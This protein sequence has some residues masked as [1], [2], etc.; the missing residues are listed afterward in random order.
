MNRKVFLNLLAS[1]WLASRAFPLLAASE[2]SKSNTAKEIVFYVSPRGNDQWTGLKPDKDGSNGPFATITRARDE[3]R[4]LKQKSGDT[5]DRPVRVILRGGTYFVNQTIKFTE[6]D[7]GSKTTPIIYQAYKNE[8]PIL[9]GGKVIN[10]WKQLKVNGKLAWTSTLPEVQQGKW[11][12]HQLWVNGDRAQRCRHPK[13]GYL[14]VE[15][16]FNTTT[17]V[18]SGQ[19]HFQYAQGDLKAWKDL[20]Q[21]EAIIMSRW[22]ESRLP[23]TSI[24]TEQQII[25]FQE[26]TPLQ[27]EA[28]NSSSS[29]A[30]TYYLENILEL[31]T[32]PGEWHL[33]H[34]TGQITYLPRQGESIY[35]SI[36]I[37]PVLSKLLEITGDISTRRSV[38]YITFEGIVF[39]HGEWYY[40]SKQNLNP[41]S[42]RV[43]LS[44]IQ[45]SANIPGYIYVQATRFCGWRKC[46]FSH[47]SNYAIE[48][49]DS[50]IENKITDCKFSDLGAGG[51]KIGGMRNPSCG[52]NIVSNCHIYNGGIIFHSA[53]GIWIGKSSNNI[54]TNNHIHDFYY[55]AI[56][57]GW[58]WGY[59]EK[60]NSKKPEAQNNIIQNNHIHD[61]GKKSNNDRPMLNDKGGIYTLGIQPGTIISGNLIHNVE[62]YNYGAAGIYLDEGSSNIL[63]DNNIVH[64]IRGYCFHLHYGRNNIIR[65]N[66]F[67]LAKIAQILYS[68]SEKEN[69]ALI[70]Q[71]N[72]IYW[73]EGKLLDGKW[74]DLNFIFDRNIYWQQGNHQ[75]KFDQLSWQNWRKQ[76]MDL[77]SE[78]IDPLFVNPS[79]GDFRLKTN[80]PALKL[81]FRK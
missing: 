77:H 63:V 15:K 27:I 42:R 39:A 19:D 38:D 65:N 43:D 45:A 16:S 64:N 11:V 36:I 44:G 46:T 47:I 34:Q 57:V 29:G 3:I 22:L 10:Q 76:G 9:S 20:E 49:T 60:S 51:I 69:K 30:G 5:L 32:Q 67:A 31:L 68:A 12:F 8:I 80:S 17:D 1:G 71:N 54:I 25:S 13:K 37:A 79:Q 55:T 73:K 81:K 48:L 62:A 70:F 66:I 24:N 26:P 75:I 40:P 4:I 74:K 6:I 41:K 50:C 18:F 53:V 14:K 56:S 33:N 61:I 2:K 21:G 7:S 72:I 23:I 78:I 52:K 28:G 35:K 58:T 59:G